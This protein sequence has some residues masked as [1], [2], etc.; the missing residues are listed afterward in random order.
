MIFTA[1]VVQW[2]QYKLGGPHELRGVRLVIK[3]VSGRK[4]ETCQNDGVRRH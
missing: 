4:A 1:S 2:L 3:D